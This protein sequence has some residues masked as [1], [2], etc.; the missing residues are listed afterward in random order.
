MVAEQGLQQLRA[1]K[2]ELASN[3]AE[4]EEK[5]AEKAA[6]HRK[7][8][9]QV[10]A[11]TSEGE[12]LNR[13]LSA[14]RQSLQKGKE[15]AD[16]LQADLERAHGQLGTSQ[17]ALAEAQESLKAMEVA[18]REQLANAQ[19]EAAINISNLQEEL[20]SASA[21]I[22]QL[23]GEL[24]LQERTHSAAELEIRQE[25]QTLQQKL[26]EE[27]TTVSGLQTNLENQTAQYHQD[28]EAWL[29]KLE[30]ER[31]EASAEA[32]R[33]QE[34]HAAVQ[35]ELADMQEELTASNR[36][37]EDMAKAEAA[38]QQ[39]QLETISGLERNLCNA[40]L[41]LAASE[42]ANDHLLTQIASLES[43][44]DNISQ[45]LQ[46]AFQDNDC[47]KQAHKEE[48]DRLLQE[49]EARTWEMEKQLNTSAQTLAAL[50]ES[51]QEV[52][53]SREHLQQELASAQSALVLHQGELAS[54]RSQVAALSAEVAEK[55]EDVSAYIA[56]LGD[57]TALCQS[58]SAQVENAQAAMRTAGSEAAAAKVLLHQSSLSTSRLVSMLSYRLADM[59][60]DQYHA[61]WTLESCNA[62]GAALANRLA[63]LQ[64]EVTN[65]AAQHQALADEHAQVLASLAVSQ[66]AK[67]RLNQQLKAALVEL[68][69]L[70]EKL[71]AVFCTTSRQAEL[72]AASDA[73]VEQLTQL[74]T[75][76]QQQLDDAVAMHEAT[77]QEADAR[78]A[79]L[80]EQLSGQGTALQAAA[81]R[82]AVLTEQQS[83]LDALVAE[84]QISLNETKC[85][86][87]KQTEHLS[88]ALNDKVALERQ[89]R[90]LQEQKQQDIS[91]YEARV[92]A[93][94]QELEKAK[95]DAATRNERLASQLH[96]A[97]QNG[98]KL[99]AELT[100]TEDRLRLSHAHINALSTE[101]E[102]Q[103][104][105][106][107]N[108]LS[109]LER[110]KCEIASLHA[111]AEEH[112]LER[113]SL[114][115]ALLSSQQ[116]TSSLRAQMEDLGQQAGLKEIQLSDA[117]AGMQRLEEAV[118]ELQG[119]CC[120]QEKEHSAAIED[121]KERLAASEK[122]A[123]SHVLELR[124]ELLNS[125]EAL[126]A[127]QVPPNRLCA[128]CLTF[129]FV[130]KH[131]SF[132]GIAAPTPFSN[133]VGQ[134]TRQ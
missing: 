9:A 105:D 100:S 98:Q 127:E 49:A 30:A 103:R 1:E 83:S 126:G 95:A 71:E 125:R 5:L 40:E 20:S 89:L 96:I 94:A 8:E 91:A 92:S 76:I 117:L 10:Q 36:K 84:L 65:M 99:E 46:S 14:L 56:Q 108:A 130:L 42:A 38:E 114:Q 39:R 79:R 107:G 43:E 77:M 3:L 86:L 119:K 73:Q 93:V 4:T 60:A 13:E 101:L 37:Q 16:S 122:T 35:Q 110:V 81:A 112:E 74:C 34:M 63:A 118:Q 52:S 88:G 19:Q 132:Q 64:V 7:L 113:R 120:Q 111:A 22:I 62:A 54:A 69:S 45:R 12:D 133:G 23:H 25:M 66:Q 41:R 97:V 90:E 102:S 87:A 106:L 85:S 128:C 70:S 80:E 123:A 31:R 17:S 55:T 21:T 57:A 53:H 121:F 58:L 50:E 2:T 18:C 28:Q 27:Q 24:E 116:D 48:V 72:L 134:F 78:Q 26:I 15:H 59:E 11:L 61:I 115:Q 82:E 47:Q 75:S 124:M 6:I 68:A 32:A 67:E 104:N 51:F 129:A 29:A 109:Q 131:M 44:K 33:L